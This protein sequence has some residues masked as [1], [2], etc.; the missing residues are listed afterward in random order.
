MR[1]RARF[2]VGLVTV[3]VAVGYLMWTGMSET[4]VYYLTP[5]ELMAKVAADPTFRELGVKVGARVV[6]GTLAADPA[7]LVYGFEVMDIETGATRFPVSY[8][9]PLPDTFKE[10]GDVVLEGRFRADGVFEAVTVL[11]KC[12]SRYEAAPGELAA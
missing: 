11:T 9:G 1:K 3:A 12:G 7:N 5:S 6:P 4:M 10:G 2:F 8:H